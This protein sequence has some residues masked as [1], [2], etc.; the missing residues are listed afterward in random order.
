MVTDSVRS[1]ATVTAL[2]G[3]LASAALVLMYLGLGFFGPVNDVLGAVTGV[4][5]ML[6]ALATRDLLPDSAAL[7]LLALAT[8]VLGAILVV[9]GSVLVV[10][11]LT[12][13]YRAGLWSSLGWGVLG[14]WFLV[15]AVGLLGSAGWPGWLR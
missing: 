9:I 4:L 15:L 8:A 5:V 11:G 12:G 13:W 1:L 14:L 10:T 7:R 3:V 2:V 6:V